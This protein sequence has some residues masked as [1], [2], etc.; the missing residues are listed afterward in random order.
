MT[1]RT[2]Y[3][4]AESGSDEHRASRSEPENE[5]VEQSGATLRLDAK[6]TRGCSAIGEKFDLVIRRRAG[7]MPS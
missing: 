4:S 7:Q 5:L 1:G 6:T 2:S 3:A